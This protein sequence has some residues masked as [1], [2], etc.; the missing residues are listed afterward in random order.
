MEIVTSAALND[1]NARVSDIEVEYNAR[2]VTGEEKEL[3]NDEYVSVH[4]ETTGGKVI[5]TST[6]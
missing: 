6:V 5:L 3:N 4:A 2:A 1:L